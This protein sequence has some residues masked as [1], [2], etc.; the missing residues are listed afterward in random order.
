MFSPGI[1]R[2]PARNRPE[3]VAYLW[4]NYVETANVTREIRR[5]LAVSMS[6]RGR[7][8]LVKPPQVWGG[9]DAD[10]EAQRLFYRGIERWVCVAHMAGRY[11]RYFAV[12]ADDRS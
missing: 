6:S 1:L 9:S 11:G 3:T 4:L 2:A 5:D 10:H 7:A 8:L 12:A